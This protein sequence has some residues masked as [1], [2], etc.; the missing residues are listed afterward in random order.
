M[1]FWLFS[2]EFRTKETKTAKK[3]WISGKPNTACTHTHNWLI[4]S[5]WNQSRCG[6]YQ[7][8]E[9]ILFFSRFFIV[10]FVFFFLFFYLF[11][12]SKLSNCCYRLRFFFTSFSCSSFL[13]N[14]TINFQ[15]K[16]L[17]CFLHILHK[18]HSK[19]CAT[20][21]STSFTQYFT[22][23]IVRPWMLFLF[24]LLHTMYAN[25]N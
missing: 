15:H 6:I 9:N 3:K 1:P 4:S 2:I 18:K 10:L 11:S 22:A 19:V 17:R 13:C 20:C 16:F 14:S 21:S 24:I 12:S 8:K 23:N 25:Q 7:V 5:E